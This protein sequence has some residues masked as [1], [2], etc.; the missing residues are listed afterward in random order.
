MTVYFDNAA[1][2]QVKIEVIREM[3]PYYNEE[4]GNPSSIYHLG[5]NAKRAIEEAREKVANLIN[6]DK[7]EIYF[8]SCGSES[9]NCAIKGIAYANQD[10]RKSYN[11]I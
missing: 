2:T 3:M 4:Y 5:R 10:K 7:N 11:N 6:A 8:T 1:T 9:D